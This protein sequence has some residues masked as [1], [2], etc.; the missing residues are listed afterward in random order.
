MDAA[1][2]PGSADSRPAADGS[3]GATDGSTGAAG[4][5][6]GLDPDTL[7]GA[8]RRLDTLLEAAVALVQEADP[9]RAG[10]R[11]RGLYVGPALVDRLLRQQPGAAPILL[12]HTGGET[13]DLPAPLARLRDTFG[14]SGF[15]IDLLLLSMAPEVDLRY[16]RLFGFLHDD[17]TRR[18]P[19]V[20]LALD[21]LCDSAADKLRRRRHLLP[22]AP[23]VRHGL[24]TLHPPGTDSRA[25]LLAHALVP[26]EAVVGYLLGDPGADRRLGT[27]AELTN[28]VPDQAVRAELAA[29]A[30][31]LAPLLP[32]GAAEPA[33]LYLH[34]PAGR[35]QPAAA[36]QLAAAWH[37][38]LLRVE[39][40][41]VAADQLGELIRPAVR[42]ADLRGAALYLGPVEAAGE[43]GSAGQRELLA[44]VAGRT[45]PTILAGAGPWA[46]LPGH[47]VG[48]LTIAFGQSSVD[49]RRRAWQAGLDRLGAGLPAP[50][51]DLL[52][53]RF[54]L[55]HGQI[56]A[57]VQTGLASERWSDPAPADSAPPDAAHT[58][59][60]AHA[61]DA[62]Q[63]P[64]A[65]PDGSLDST[66]VPGRGS[67]A[68]GVPAA[69]GGPVPAG[70]RYQFL[71]AA[72]RAQAGAALDRLAQRV[73]IRHGW[74]DLILPAAD[75][76]QL[77]DLAGWV[78]NRSVVLD[79]WGFARHVPPGGG[80]T[81]LFTG[82]SGAGKTLAAGILAGQLGY[83]LFRVDL[84]RVVSK[85]IG[86][87]EKNLDAVFTAA[88]DANA[89]LLIDEA[90]ALFGRRSA[91]QD[92]HDRYANLE[93]AYLLQKMEDFDGIAVLATNLRDNL[94]QAFLRRL[95]FV[96]NF[97]FPDSASRRL[98]WQRLWPAT[99]PLAADVDL[100][101][102]AAEVALAG[103]HLRN[104][105]VAAAHRAAARSTEITLTD[106]LISAAREYAKL[107]KV[108]PALVAAAPARPV[109]GRTATPAAG[110][111]A[112]PTSSRRRNGRRPADVR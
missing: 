111:V 68:P 89:V 107:G 40:D 55:S 63:E 41:R 13:A 96:V 17:L 77:R 95:A 38:P 33:L 2:A 11:F 105:A 67:G 16:E 65:E 15:D 98:I 108:P 4:G 36:A 19:S 51:L 61:P 85:Y 3:T 32:A 18:R 1:G 5:S 28:P 27:A 52:A 47:P 31:G 71:A 22:G 43:P 20:D 23:L 29:V 101:L 78:D 73:P 39:L 74:S 25:P 60:A 75:L 104:I 90:D 102:L 57:A 8:L 86:E 50:A 26:D 42:T 24:L 12:A 66:T 59:N 6:T 81:A 93:V 99:A 64:S 83:D 94:D 110:P 48:V 82:P 45:G 69:A 34:G 49:G 70:G 106:V 88:A 37:R 30:P 87:T 84:A 72:A 46:A 7:V 44:A 109:P 76:A 53:S 97:P 103:G 9:E 80:I 10:D 112:V 91:V 35:G 100:D 21:L 14:L 58:P 92:A 54:R 79:G 62:A 56:A